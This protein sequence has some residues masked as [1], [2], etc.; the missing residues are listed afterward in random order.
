MLQQPAPQTQPPH[1]PEQLARQQNAL[2]L[3]SIERHIKAGHLW[4]CEGVEATN[5]TGQFKAINYAISWE[6][7]DAMFQVTCYAG[8]NREYR[9]WYAQYESLRM[10]EKGQPL[11]LSKFHLL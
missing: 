3:E 5:Y 11:T 8:T 1:S 6:R 4:V 9:L 7:E 10:L 2:T